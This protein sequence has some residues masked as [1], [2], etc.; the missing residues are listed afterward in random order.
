VFT[1]LGRGVGA[2]EAIERAIQVMFRDE[3][4]SGV[5]VGPISFGSV[6]ETDGWLQRQVR[7]R[8]RADEE[9]A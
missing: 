9:P 2:S 3:T 8:V 7:I 4:I 5:V 6:G 1:P